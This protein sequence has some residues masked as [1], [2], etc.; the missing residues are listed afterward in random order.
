MHGS[1][2]RG[3]SIASTPI[4]TTVPRDGTTVKRRG[5]AIADCHRAKPRNMDAEPMCIRSVPFTTTRMRL[6]GLSFVALSSGSTG[7]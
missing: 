6:G 2:G 1:A 5:G 4:A 3:M 7:A